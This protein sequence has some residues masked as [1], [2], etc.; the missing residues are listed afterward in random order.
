MANASIAAS[1]A[2]WRSG[3]LC[4]NG[5]AVALR[6]LREKRQD[7]QPENG[8]E[9]IVLCWSVAPGS[10]QGAEPDQRARMPRSVLLGA[11]CAKIEMWPAAP[12]LVRCERR[13]PERAPPNAPHHLLSSSSA[14]GDTDVLMV[15]VGIFLLVAA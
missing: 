15:V 7:N 2:V 8:G 6:S 10:A 1:R 12:M 13:M 4:C 5:A 9:G 14:P 3:H 11:H